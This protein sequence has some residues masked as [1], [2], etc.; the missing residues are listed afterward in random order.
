[1]G[2]ETID[3]RDFLNGE[4]FTEKRF[5]ARTGENDWSAYF[6]KQILVRGC[7]SVIVPPWAYMLIALRLAPHA[8][9]IRFGNEHDN[10]VIYRKSRDSKPETTTGNRYE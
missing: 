5:L 3:P 10:I 2:Y 1:M 9:T 4:A 7:E 6:D 8:K